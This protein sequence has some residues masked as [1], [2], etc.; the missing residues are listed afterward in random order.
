MPLQKLE[1]GSFVYLVYCRKTPEDFLEFRKELVSCATSD[2]RKRDIVLD[3]TDEET[4]GDGEVLLLSN[5]VKSF[6]GA[7][8][9][10][11]V[12]ASKRVRQKLEGHHLFKYGNAVGYEN[13][14][15]LLKELNGFLNP[16]A[17]AST[18]T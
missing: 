6:A 3:L 7:K 9:K 15:E 13:R 1:K 18:A 12:L 10:L 2:Q 16:S 14:E 8:R 5:I 4:I 17:R 11:W